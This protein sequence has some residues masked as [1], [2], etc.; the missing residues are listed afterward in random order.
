MKI[1]IKQRIKNNIESDF[2]LFFCCCL[3]TPFKRFVIA[4]DVCISLFLLLLVFLTRESLHQM[5]IIKALLDPWEIN[6]VQ[7]I[8]KVREKKFSLSS[9]YGLYNVGS[10]CLL[11]CPNISNFSTKKIG[12]ESTIMD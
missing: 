7:E 12:F 8:R 3:K 5:M 9:I 6:C 4:P 10:V 2:S 1:K 11:V